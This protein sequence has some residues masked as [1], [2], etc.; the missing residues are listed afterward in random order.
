MTLIANVFPKL[1]TPENVIR[2]MFK[3]CHFN[4]PLKKQHGKGTQ[5]LLKSE[6]RPLYNI[7]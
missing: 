5:T 3:K 7:Y 1:R 2:E 6:R 4:L